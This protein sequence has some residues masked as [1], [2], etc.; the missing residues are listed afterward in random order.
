[1][2]L[3]CINIDRVPKLSYYQLCPAPFNARLVASRSSDNVIMQTLV[4]FLAGF[5]LFAGAQACSDDTSRLDRCSEEFERKSNLLIP[6]IEAGRRSHTAICPLGVELEQ[7]MMRFV[8]NMC[9]AFSKRFLRPLVRDMMQAAM[10]EAGC[11]YMARRD[12]QKL[13]ARVRSLSKAEAL[14]TE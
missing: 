9:D 6:D 7:C 8:N 2:W 12:T 4:V 10:Q 11:H 14:T 1:M 13:V 5:A 3:F